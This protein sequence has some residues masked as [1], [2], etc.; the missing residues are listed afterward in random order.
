MGLRF[1]LHF[2]LFFQKISSDSPLLHRWETHLTSHFSVKSELTNPLTAS[3]YCIICLMTSD[4]LPLLHGWLIY[5]SFLYSFF[6][7]IY[8]CISHHAVSW[9][10]FIRKDCFGTVESSSKPVSEHPPTL[11]VCVC[12]M[13]DLCSLSR[14]W[15]Y[16]PC[17]RSMQSFLVIGFNFLY[18]GTAK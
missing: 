15:T 3:S 12:S 5:S 9:S 18:W 6:C 8:T 14:G 13:W 2:L 11:S 1:L 16:A 17:R 7:S 10:R 4:S